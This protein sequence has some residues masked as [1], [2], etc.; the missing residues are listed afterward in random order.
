MNLYVNHHFQERQRI[1][2]DPSVSSPCFI[3]HNIS[4]DNFIIHTQLRENQAPAYGTNGDT[5]RDADSDSDDDSEDGGMA[6]FRDSKNLM[7]AI[8]KLNANNVWVSTRHVAG[9]LLRTE[10]GHWN[11]D[12]KMIPSLLQENVALVC[13]TNLYRRDK[14]R[15]YYDET[16]FYNAEAVPYFCITVNPYIFQNMMQEVAL[17]TRVPCG[18]YFCCQGGDAAHTGGSEDYVSIRLA[19]FLVALLFIAIW[20][21]AAMPG[22]EEW[23]VH[24]KVY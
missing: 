9:G 4:H 3:S 14:G 17:S 16:A 20:I 15:L 11:E 23:T 24:D 13:D 5:N 7:N 2:K 12:Y 22:D 19:W 6:S 1:A 21:A 10:S 18:M 8:T